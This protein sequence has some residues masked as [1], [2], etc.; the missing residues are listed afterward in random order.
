MSPHQIPVYPGSNP[1]STFF[2]TPV[3]QAMAINF[4][5][6][7]YL[8]VEVNF[9]RYENR[10]TELSNCTSV[11]SRQGRLFPLPSRCLSEA[12]GAD[13]FCLVGFG[14]ARTASALQ[15]DS[16]SVVEKSELNLLYLVLMRVLYRLNDVDTLFRFFHGDFPS[17]VYDVSQ[18]DLSLRLSLGRLQLWFLC[19]TPMQKAMRPPRTYGL[20]VADW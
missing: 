11:M 14:H 18:M 8:R 17:S 7:A 12:A 19:L 6:E 13:H 20:F 4:G 10:A 9:T 5:N 16:I 1:G 15:L 2:L 3:I